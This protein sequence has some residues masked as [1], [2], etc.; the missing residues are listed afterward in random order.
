MLDALRCHL[1]KSQRAAKSALK[2]QS[3]SKQEQVGL[4]QIETFDE[5]AC[6]KDVGLIFALKLKIF[7]KFLPFEASNTPLDIF[8]RSRFLIAFDPS[9]DQKIGFLFSPNGPT[10]EFEVVGDGTNFIDLRDF[11]F[12]VN[13]KVLQS[14]SN[15]FHFTTGDAAAS[16]LPIFVNITLNSLFFDCSVC[17]NGSKVSSSNGNYERKILVETE[18]CQN[19]EARDTCLKSQ[20]YSC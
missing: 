19:T 20:E 6:C 4:E 10:L 11:Y 14:D 16:D 5:N 13:C 9:I 3:K 1:Q 15:T 7:S 8:E 18:F 2:K 17:A 12:Q